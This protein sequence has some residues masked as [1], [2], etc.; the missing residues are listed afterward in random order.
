MSSFDIVIFV[1]VFS[2]IVH[3]NLI[4]DYVTSNDSIYEIHPCQNADELVIL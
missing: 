2:V 3:A 4:V 1:Y